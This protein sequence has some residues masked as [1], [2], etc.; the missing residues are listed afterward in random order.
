MEHADF[1]AGEVG[2]LRR[3]TGIGAVADAVETMLGAGAVG[4]RGGGGEDR[5]VA[6]ELSAVGVDDRPAGRL[7]QR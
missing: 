3:R 4:G 1:G 5:Q 6:V 7:G 2:P